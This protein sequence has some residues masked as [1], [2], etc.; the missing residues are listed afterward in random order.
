[1][2]RAEL[3]VQKIGYGVKVEVSKRLKRRIYNRYFQLR[4]AQ[5]FARKQ[6]SN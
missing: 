3:D 4:I 6:G 1:M 2:K 5:M